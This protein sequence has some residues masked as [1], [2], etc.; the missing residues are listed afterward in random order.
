MV[1]QISIKN[2]NFPSISIL[3]L[4]LLLLL[5]STGFPAA[6]S[7]TGVFAVISAAAT[8][9]NRPALWMNHESADHDI[10]LYCFRGPRYDYTGVIQNQDTSQV[11]TGLNT[12]GFALVYTTTV[13]A[14][15]VAGQAHRRLI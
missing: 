6:G 9:D 5:H 11:I 1:T 12:T 2:E 4:I 3:C 7:E 14:D 10:A 8:C 13:I 15:S